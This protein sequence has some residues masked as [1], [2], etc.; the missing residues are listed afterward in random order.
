M[1][2]DK[3]QKEEECNDSDHTVTTLLP[4]ADYSDSR[5]SFTNRTCS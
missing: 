3:Q 1:T 5:F 2:I 4:N